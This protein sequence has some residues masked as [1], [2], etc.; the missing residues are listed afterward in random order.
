MSTNHIK[1][2]KQ[3]TSILASD[4]HELINELWGNSQSVHVYGASMG[5][6]VAQN[7]AVLLL[8]DKRLKS[9]CLAVTARCHGR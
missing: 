8:R 5:G 1:L 4:T 7:L 9:L 6:M 3:T 2:E